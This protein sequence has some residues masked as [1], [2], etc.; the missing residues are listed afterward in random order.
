MSLSGGSDRDVTD[1]GPT[2]PTSP[3]GAS[4]D[5]PP[6]NEPTTDRFQEQ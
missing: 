6:L 5:P 1:V 3:S 4:R 2:H